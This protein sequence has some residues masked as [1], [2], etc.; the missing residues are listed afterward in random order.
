MNMRL[1]NLTENALKRLSE[2]I[3]KTLNEC[4]TRGKQLELIHK[5]EQTLDEWRNRK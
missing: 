2:Q 1:F 3:V 5:L 4:E